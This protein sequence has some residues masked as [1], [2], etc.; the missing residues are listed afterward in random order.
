[1]KAKTISNETPPV[2]RPRG[3]NAAATRARILAAAQ[4]IFSTRGY[5]DAALRDIASEA[6]ANV[7]L[8]VR[9]FGSKEKLFEAALQATLTR[10]TL[11]NLPRD[12]Y[13]QQVV[14]NLIEDAVDVANPLPMLAHA[15]SDAVAQAV[16]LRF[17]REAVVAPIAEWLGGKDA[18]QRAAEIL[19]ICAGFYTYRYLLPLDCF[20]GPMTPGARKWLEDTLQRVI[21]QEP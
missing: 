11:W 16:A 14:R 10:E 15:A 4:R 19:A 9:Y 18:E 1:M 5:G 12:R 2:P 3:R 21:D 6:D 20:A 8:I 7:S 17:I 13:G